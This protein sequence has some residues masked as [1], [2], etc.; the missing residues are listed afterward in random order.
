VLKARQLGVSWLAALYALWTAIRRPGQSVLLIS[1]NQADA[2]KLLDKVAFLYNHLPTWGPEATI[3]L[4]SI[5]FPALGSEIEA[6]PATENVGR[7]RTAAL[8]VLDEHAHQPHAQ[9]ILLAVKA[10]AE[11]GQLLSISSANGQGALHSRIYLAARQDSNGWKAVF[12]PAEAHP[13]RRVPGWR[14]RE[15]AAL[16]QLSDAAFAQEYPSSDLEA[17][18]TTG[19]PVFG[20]EVLERQPVEDGVAG[21]PGLTMYR[22]PEPG[23]IYVIGADVAE[24]LERS[25]W[26]SAV[27]LERDS[28]EQVAQL[29]GRWTPDVYAAKLHELAVRYC[30]HASEQHRHPVI[31]AVERNNHGHAVLLRLVQLHADSAAYALYR[32]K[33]R[34]LGWVTS[35][36]TRPVLVDQL[37]AALRLGE[38]VLHDAATVD[39][40]QTFSWSD[41]G[42]PEAQEGYFDDDVLALGIAWQVRRRAFVRVIG[43]RGEVTRR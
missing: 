42:R 20:A 28:G 12:I 18:Q 33:D 2:Q 29:R 8:V 23:R 1:R 22:D 32:A 27:V 13:D 41:D 16:G 25:D 11:Q 30:P 35:S 17:I 39:Q 24:G 19:R 34:R 5:R 14:E 26:C 38:I 10:V 21:A 36:A 37:E 6:L 15:R 3:N 31:L 40:C 43:V 4:R 7:S 9:R